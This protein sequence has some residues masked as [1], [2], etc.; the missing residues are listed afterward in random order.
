MYVI[1]RLSLPVIISEFPVEYKFPDKV[2]FPVVL[3]FPDEYIS[4]ATPNPPA[5]TNAPVVAPVELLVLRIVR[6]PLDT[7]RLF[8]TTMLFAY[9]FP[10]FKL[11]ASVTLP[12]D[13]EL[14]LREPNM[15]PVPVPPIIIFSVFAPPINTFPLLVPPIV[16]FAPPIVKFFVVDAPIITLLPPILRLFVFVPPTD[17]FIVFAPP[18]VM[19]VVF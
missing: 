15:D 3:I 4:F 9:M 16:T 1:V 6:I 13:S 2:I 10:V 7:S 19:L 18:I 17:T 8:V 5:T 11:L 14:T 12:N